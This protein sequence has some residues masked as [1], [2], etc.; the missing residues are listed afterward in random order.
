MPAAVFKFS[1]CALSPVN[2]RTRDFDYHLPSHLIAQHPAIPRD[3]SKLLIYRPANDEIVHTHFRNIDKFLPSD[4]LL[5]INQ[6]RVIPARFWAKKPTGAQIEVLALQET[7]PAT[8]TA[9]C[10]PGKRL[11]QGDI[12]QTIKGNYTLEIVDTGM[13][14]T[15]KI[16]SPVTFST[17]LKNIGVMPLPPYIKREPY[18]P[19]YLYDEKKYQTVYARNA[20]SVAAPTAGLHFTTELLSRLKK[21][22]VEITRLT[23]H[24][25]AGTFLPVK[26][27]DVRQHVMHEEWVEISSKTAQTIN[28]ARESNRP[29]IAVGTTCVRALE[30]AAVEKGLIEPFKGKTSLMIL[31]GYEFK[32]ITGMITNFH[33][34][35]STLLMLVCALAGK[36]KILNLYQEA[37]ERE[38][39]FYSYGD[40]MLI[41]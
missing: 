16:V 39:R 9:F 3:S 18:D 22:G 38:Y 32:A 19:D 20:G 21:N 29:V 27:E 15:L 35:R 23:L 4:T 2:M 14:F 10:K 40:A 13:E 5:V 12:I 30:T 41:F 24:V 11:K 7:A 6:T 1:I 37:I 26:T 36:D 25:G 34:P 33:L 8:F 28:Q 17:L 31:P